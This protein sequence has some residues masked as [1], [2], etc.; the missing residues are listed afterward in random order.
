MKPVVLRPIAASEVEDAYEW[1]QSKGDGLGERFL[2]ELE[3]VLHRV[4][5][6]PARIHV[7]RRDTRRA[8]LSRF[9]YSVLFRELADRILVVAVFH[10]RRDPRRVIDR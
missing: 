9:P 3:S 7:L 8:L 6:Q 10:A 1:Y 4:A 2:A 5:K